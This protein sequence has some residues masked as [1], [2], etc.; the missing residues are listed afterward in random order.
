[1]IA[2]DEGVM[3][4]TR[5]H[6][7]ILD[8]LEVNGGVIAVTKTDLVDDPEWLDLVTS[9]V[10]DQVEGTCMENAPIVRVSARTGQGL[11]A[12]VNAPASDPAPANYQE[13][14]YIKKMR[15]DPWQREY[16][17]LSPGQHG[18]IDIYSL[19][20]DGIEGGEG[21]NKDIGNWSTD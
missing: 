5:E 9:D 13:G 15:K 10:L 17:Y 19:G 20:A 8:L 14:G 12:L 7:A 11:E 21:P 18:E 4:Q 3:P 6:I 1:M 2:A 16:M